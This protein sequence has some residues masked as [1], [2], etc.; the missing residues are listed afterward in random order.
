MAHR[1]RAPEMTRASRS[2]SREHDIVIAPR[3]PRVPSHE[4]VET[5]TEYLVRVIFP[6]TVAL[7]DLRW[8]LIGDVFEVEY[9]ASGWYYYENFLVPATPAPKVSVRERVFEAQFPKVA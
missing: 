9:A 3:E 4:I 6:G 7:A 1:L 8:E 2:R 5:P